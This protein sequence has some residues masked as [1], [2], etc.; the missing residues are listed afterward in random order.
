ML[1][2]LPIELK[3]DMRRVIC[4]TYN[5]NNKKSVNAKNKKSVKRICNSVARLNSQVLQETF[6]TLLKEFS[7]RHKNFLKILEDAYKKIEKNV[8]E[9]FQFD[10][11]QRLLI[12]SYFVMEYALE[13]AAL[14][15]PSMVVHPRQD[16]KDG[17]KILMSLRAAGEGHISSLEFIE[18]YVDK[19]GNLELLERSSR[20]QLPEV[21]EKEI[22]RSVVKFEDDI[23]FSE[24]VIFPLTE[25]ESNGIEDV[26]L[27]LFTDGDGSKKY[28]GT[29]TAYDGINIK[30][31]LIT[32]TDFKKYSICS[33]NGKAIKDKGMALFPRKIN[34]KYAMISR[35]D[36]E[37]LRLMYSDDI[38]RYIIQTPEFPWQLS[39]IGNCGSPIELEEG[40]LLLIH[41]VGPLRKY[42]IGAYLLDLDNPSKILKRT[43]QPMLEAKDHEREGYVPNVVYSCGGICQ[44]GRIFI[45]F[46]MSDYATGIATVEVNELLNMME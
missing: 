39:K 18:G 32:T 22:E 6:D 29:F 44:Y 12:G 14:F 30:S 13:C 1:K 36:G 9:K 15:N 20:C 40:W 21:L 25:D 46:A 4:F 35:Q 45:P 26:R 33:M 2:R 38:L 8:P 19:N 17:L 16:R 24:Q 43:F 23:P 10:K 3:P 42:V 7:S 37:N 41:G 31:K 5:I 34:G 28:L 27:V 11:T